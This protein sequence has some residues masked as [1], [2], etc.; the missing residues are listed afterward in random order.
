MAL[1]QWTSMAASCVYTSYW[2][3]CWSIVRAYTCSRKLQQSCQPSLHYIV[4]KCGQVSTELVGLAGCTERASAAPQYI[5]FT[6]P[7]CIFDLQQ[8][9][10]DPITNFE[11]NKPK[12]E[13]VAAPRQLIEMTKHTGVKPRFLLNG[14]GTP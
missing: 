12:I 14:T 9:G 5:R 11:T 8:P 13:G 4:C 7:K 2:V 10:H 1:S 6:F 3:R